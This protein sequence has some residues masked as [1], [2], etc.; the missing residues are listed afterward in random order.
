MSSLAT[1]IS[2]ASSPCT[3]CS[4]R[5]SSASALLSLMDAPA[6]SLPRWPD[7]SGTAAF[8]IDY[9]FQANA[10]AVHTN[11]PSFSGMAP[12]I[13]AGIGAWSGPCVWSLEA[14]PAGRDFFGEH[15]ALVARHPGV[16]AQFPVRRALEC[17]IERAELL[18]R[19]D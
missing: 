11:E 5:I 16:V 15:I 10:D 3:R 8:Q 13:C 17:L 4:R 18:G 6:P 19:V 12:G 7:R 14:R 2:N 9:S 1:M